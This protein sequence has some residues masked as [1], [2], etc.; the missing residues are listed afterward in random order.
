[1]ALV[2]VVVRRRLLVR[3]N[4]GGGFLVNLVAFVLQPA[5]YLKRKSFLRGIKGANMAWKV[6]AVIVYTPSTFRR[7]FG[8]HPEMVEVSRLGAGRFMTIDTAKPV[9]RR[10][11][12]KLAKQGI[13]VPTLAER[14]ADGRRW[15]ATQDAARRAS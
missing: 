8:K 5:A 6:V 3:A 4:F 15:A 2:P 14:K 1:M 9:T 13:T 7:V 11:R 12:R 10:R